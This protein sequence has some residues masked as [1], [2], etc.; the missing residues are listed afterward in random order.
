MFV[1]ILRDYCSAWCFLNQACEWLEATNVS[2]WKRAGKLLKLSQYNCQRKYFYNDNWPSK[3]Q[4]PKLTHCCRK[5]RASL[6]Q[7][8][9][10]SKTICHGELA[11]CA[12]T[13]K[14]LDKN[15]PISCKKQ[16]DLL[17]CAFLIQVSMSFLKKD[18]KRRMTT[19]GFY[20]LH[21]L[22]AQDRTDLY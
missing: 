10:S 7:M 17:H 2:S 4:Q 11:Y 20:D 14:C 9:V 13:T 16:A 1:D 22:T 8:G 12:H 18:K 6:S 15:P 19:L 21:T 3:N 5:N